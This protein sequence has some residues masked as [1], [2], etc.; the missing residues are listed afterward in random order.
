MTQLRRTAATAEAFGLECE[1]IS[2]ARATSALPAAGDGGPARGAVAARRRH[3]QRDRRDGQP[4]PGRPPAGC[5]DLRGDPR[6]GDHHAPAVPS[7]ACRTDRGHIEAEIVVNCAGQWAKAIGA[8]CG[9]HVPLHSAE[10][11][12]VV[13]EQIDGVAPR[14]ADPA[15]PRRLHLL[16]GGG[17]RAAGRWLRAGGQAVGGARPDALPVRVPAARRGL[18]PLCHPDGQRHP[19]RSRSWPRRGSRSSTTAPRAS[20]PT[21]SSCSARPRR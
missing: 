11:F 21:T 10:H 17:R 2:P 15:R 14:P 13:T 6:D 9:V 1:L 12:Y 8:M 4:G 16:P 3:R 18:G 5:D 20:P 19:A 7:A